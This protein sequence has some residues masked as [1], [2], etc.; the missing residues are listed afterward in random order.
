MANIG[1]SITIKGDL[2]GNEDL[3]IDGT[4]E[5]RIDLPNNQLTIGADGEVKAEVTAKAVTVIG[6]VTGNL[7]ATD[8]IE[9]EGAGIV[10]GDVR[11]PR[12]IIQEGAVLNGAVEMGHKA[13]GAAAASASPPK[14][15]ASSSAGASAEG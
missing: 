11:A 5:G 15:V 3:Q 7:T 14:P 12:L 6:H 2:T 10:D 4:V 1:K 8:K 13:S 9:V